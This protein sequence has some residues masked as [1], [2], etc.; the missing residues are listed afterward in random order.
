MKWNEIKEPFLIQI[1][2]NRF[3]FPAEP[4]IFPSAH[5]SLGITRGGRQRTQSCAYS[6]MLGSNAGFNAPHDFRN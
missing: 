4:T 5:N 6:R 2:S 3:T 1:S